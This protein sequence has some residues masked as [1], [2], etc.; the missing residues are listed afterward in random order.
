[1][2]GRRARMQ[3]LVFFTAGTLLQKGGQFLL[4]PLLIGSMTTAEFARYGQFTAAIFILIP[5]CSINIHVAGGRLYFDYTSRADQASLMNS[6]LL[7]GTLAVCTSIAA[8]GGLLWATGA[9]DSLTLGDPQLILLVGLSVISAV[10]VQFYVLVFRLEDRPAMFAI[11]S[12]VL[13]F[14]LLISYAVLSP[15]F[16][17]K[18]LASVVAYLITN[19]ITILVSIVASRPY[20]AGGRIR[21]NVI[22][23][24]VSFGSGTMVQNVMTWINGQSGRWIGVMI[25]PVSALAGYTLMSY[26]TMAANLAA[27]V[28]FETMRIDI[29]GSQAR[30]DIVRAR[31]LIGLTTYA[32]LAITILVYVIVFVVQA[33]QSNFLPAGYHIGADLVAASALFSCLQVVFL[34]SVWLATSHKRTKTLALVAVFSAALTLVASWVL[35][36][37][38]SDLGLMLG[39]VVGTAVQALLGNLL[40]ARILSPKAAPPGN[41]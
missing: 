17:D 39:A 1:M 21:R 30:G 15:Y 28:L 41:S 5:L 7:W 29:M 32:S 37:I 33:Y 3:R 6:L 35:G 34:R 22:G 9:Q 31:R 23:P 10:V 19:V 13:G 2:S 20:L 40:M 8:L 18:L 38:Y 24:A 25:M 11:L 12:A 36:Q 16:H 14:G 26:V 4:L 27:L